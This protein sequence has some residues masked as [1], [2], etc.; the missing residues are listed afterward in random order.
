MKSNTST[1]VGPFTQ[2]LSMSDLPERGPISDNQLQVITNA[3]IAIENGKIVAIG[4]Y[5]ELK[6][7]YSNEH[8]IDSPAVAL[9]GFIDS[10]THL[11][12]AG[13]RAA[14]YAL[15][16]SGS[17]YLDI[18]KKGGG[19]LDSVAKTR[20]ASKDELTALTML[21]CERLMQLGITTCEV[22]SGYG[23]SVD[24]E[25]KI[26]Q[27]IASLNE[28]QPVSLI[29]TC[30]AAHTK[31]PEFENNNLYLA[32]LNE[33]LLPLIK[34]QNLCQRIDIF[35]DDTAFSVDE[36]RKYLLE[37]QRLGFEICIHADQ[38]KCGGSRL[39]AELKA[40]SADHL[41][42][43]KIEDFKA[44]VKANVA[45]IALPGA[46]LGL[47]LP[48]PHAR[49]MLDNGLCVAIASDW[50]PGS[51]PMGN[52]LS[53]AAILG[54]AE[55]L[56]ITETLAGVT[57]RAARA[58]KL[59]DRGILKVGQRADISIFPTNDYREILYYQGSMLP[60]VL[61]ILGKRFL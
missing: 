19:I 58:L 10:H 39:A 14:D 36:A 5:N 31:P 22:K 16:V 26:L 9:P 55:H 7:Q 21:R 32:Y 40:V 43:S 38:F 37:A 1:L 29:P 11:V 27:V 52:L 2:L 13:S 56:T 54:A 12:F 23:L 8:Y 49:Q 20:A 41:E 59:N 44:L 17:S 53:Q 46:S 24:E 60:N 48:Q 18:A 15:R 6:G 33:K 50:N 25:V 57:F 51:A 45:A 4:P 61:Y 28:L 3:A 30:L 35:V 47:G 42:N 34:K